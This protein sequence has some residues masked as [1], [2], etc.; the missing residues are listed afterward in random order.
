[1]HDLVRILELKLG[2]AFVRVELTLRRV[3]GVWGSGIC[4]NKA[5]PLVE[6]ECTN[7]STV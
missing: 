1:M 7:L 5:T 3:V 4:S 6:F 2:T